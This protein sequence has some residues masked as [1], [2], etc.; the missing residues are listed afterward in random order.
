M[1]VVIEGAF[2]TNPADYQQAHRSIVE[3]FNLGE[4][5]A[6]GVIWYERDHDTVTI[7]PVVWVKAVDTF[8][9]EESCGSGTIA[10]GKVTGITSIVQP[11]G[12]RIAAG[13]AEGVVTLESEM[14]V[15]R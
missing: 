2:P 6:V 15:V 13:I 8:F 5:E 7:H 1:H 11:T 12:K 14:E 3:E 10:V 9:Y 4:R